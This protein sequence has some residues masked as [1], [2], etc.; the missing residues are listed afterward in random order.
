MFE[1]ILPARK[2]K[3]EPLVKIADLDK[4][5]T[6]K[7]VFVLHGKEHIISPPSLMSW[8]E[9]VEANAKLFA[10]KDQ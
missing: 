2:Q 10:M 4:I 8:L 7:C 3:Q 5:A 9:I 6:R 1:N